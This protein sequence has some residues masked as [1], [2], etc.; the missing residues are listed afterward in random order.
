MRLLIDELRAFV[1]DNFLFGQADGLLTDD[2][3]FL[4]SG[5]VDSTGMLEL[6]GFVERTYGLRLEDEELI[7]DNLDS[8]QRLV[9]FISRKLDRSGLA[10][11]DP[12]LSH[13]E[14]LGVTS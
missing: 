9:Q 2:T 13:D 12:A 14:A 7:P 10:Q 5:I 8:L 4:A 1:T 11:G 6:I 3:S